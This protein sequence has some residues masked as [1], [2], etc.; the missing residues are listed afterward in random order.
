MSAN[1]KSSAKPK[2]EEF[3]ENDHTDHEKTDHEKTDTEMTDNDDNNSQRSHQDFEEKDTS[4]EVFELDT[5][6]LA[7]LKGKAPGKFRKPVL[8]YFFIKLK[9][10]Q[11]E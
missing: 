6:M 1:V 9:V 11:G 8:F 5:N 3:S 7:K 10:D 4:D 2:L